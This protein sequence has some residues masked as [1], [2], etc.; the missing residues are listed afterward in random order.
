MMSDD[1]DDTVEKRVTITVE[2]C[3]L[4]LSEDDR[5]EALEELEDAVGSLLDERIG[6]ADLTTRSGYQYAQVDNRCPRCGGRL[7][8]RGFNY[9][10]NGACA[11]ANCAN[12]PDCKWTGTAIYRLI[13]F[14]GGPGAA[15]ESAVITGEITPL[16]Y[17]Y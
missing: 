6:P 7:E 3:P 12:V 15:A 4:P 9:L 16:Y 10:E 13:D 11:E 2:D 8:L 5:E 17:P 14:E 1:T